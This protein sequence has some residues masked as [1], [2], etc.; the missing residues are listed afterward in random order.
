M[1]ALIQ[2]DIPFFKKF[3]N[4]W[5]IHDITRTYLSNE[6]TRRRSD[7]KAELEACEEEQAASDEERA[8]STKPIKNK[9]RSIFGKLPFDDE[10]DLAD[11]DGEHPSRPQSRKL[12]RFDDSDMEID[13]DPEIKK[14]R[15]K[16]NTK[17]LN[18]KPVSHKKTPTKNL[19]SDDDYDY[20]TDSCIS[21]NEKDLH[22]LMKG[23]TQKEKNTKTAMPPKGQKKVTDPGALF[24]S[25]NVTANK[26]KEN[27]TP[28]TATKRKAEAFPLIGSPPSKKAS[29]IFLCICVLPLFLVRLSPKLKPKHRYCPPP[30]KRKPKTMKPA[31][32]S[33]DDEDNPP[34]ILLTW[35]EL[36]THCPAALCSDCLPSEPVNAILSLFNKKKGLT[37]A[38]GP[39]AKGAAFT[40]LEICQAITLHKRR[41]SIS[42]LGQQR[43]WPQEIDWNEVRDRIFSMKDRIVDLFQSSEKLEAC[44][45]WDQFL[46][47]IDYKIFDFAAS[48]SKIDFKTAIQSKR[49]GYYGP[50]GEFVIYS[51]L[52]R[53][54]AELD[55]NEEQLEQDLCSNLHA[56]ITEGN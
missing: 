9:K 30:S 56:L 17:T 16:P 52:L 12:L 18:S 7:L 19:P 46:L 5:P 43:R 28:K 32:T 40:E 10:D 48:K 25:K 21:E 49:C 2:K 55:T 4:G 45:I 24:D 34:P 37:D 22:K 1:I 8:K 3:Q 35:K 50:Q 44:P 27:Q 38:G 41:H 53:L 13:D 23:S 31:P 26:G 51:C 39:T 15:V 42:R 11:I 14:S 33:E 20:N 47:A 29:H 36:P 6:Q 54:I